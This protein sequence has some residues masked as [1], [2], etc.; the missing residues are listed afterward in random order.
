MPSA[1]TATAAPMAR[2]QPRAT[3][4]IVPKMATSAGQPIMWSSDVSASIRPSI[5]TRGTVKST[6]KIGLLRLSRMRSRRS[7]SAVKKGPE[8]ERG[9]VPVPWKIT[10]RMAATTNRPTSQTERGTVRWPR[11]AGSEIAVMG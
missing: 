2:R 11:M 1:A 8:F 9:C 4:P 3:R 5:A 10:K 7:L 6:R